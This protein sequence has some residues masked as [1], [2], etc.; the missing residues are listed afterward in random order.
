MTDNSLVE[1][2]PLTQG[3]ETRQKTLVLASW[4]V[5]LAKESMNVDVRGDCV[6]RGHALTWMKLIETVLTPKARERIA[7]ARDRY[8]HDK[9]ADPE[10]EKSNL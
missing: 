8:W 10:D 7:A 4:W 2:R 1:T 3:L 6:I 5:F 9:G